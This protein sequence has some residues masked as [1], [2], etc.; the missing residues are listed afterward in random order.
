VRAKT[1]GVTSAKGEAAKAV[2][3]KA[4]GATAKDPFTGVSAPVRAQVDAALEATANASKFAT[5][6]KYQRAAERWDQV[7]PGLS[8]PSARTECLWRI[9]EARV[10]AW[11]YDPGLVRKNAATRA[12]RAVLGADPSG[13]QRDQALRWM[14]ELRRVPTGRD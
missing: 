10:G 3:K 11:R 9:A 1:P 13:P 12:C 5:A 7:L 14:A 6:A 4:K 8:K 2:A